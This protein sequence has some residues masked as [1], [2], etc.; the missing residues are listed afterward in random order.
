[1]WIQT[2]YPTQNG[3]RNSLV[4]TMFFFDRVLEKLIGRLDSLNVTQTHKRVTEKLALDDIFYPGDGSIQQ[5]IDHATTVKNIHG[6]KGGIS[7]Y[8]WVTG[9][10]QRHPLID[11]EMV[12][13]IT[14]TRD[15]TGPFVSRLHRK[16]QSS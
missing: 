14:D 13:P 15:T 3:S 16:T 2:E 7:P 8:S 12:P 9:T 11:S 5:L 10:H 6:T 1:M 4:I